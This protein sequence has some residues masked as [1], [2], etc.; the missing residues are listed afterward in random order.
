MKT[1]AILVSAQGEQN[2]GAD[3]VRVQKFL[4]ISLTMLA[5]SAI[6]A[7]W[8]FSCSPV[9]SPRIKVLRRWEAHRGPINDLVFSQDRQFLISAGWDGKIRLWKVK[10]G[11]LIKEFHQS[12]PVK[13]VSLSPNGKMLVTSGYD[14]T[15]KIWRFEDGI[16]LSLLKELKGHKDWVHDAVFSPDGQFLASGGKDAT[17]KI[18]I[19]SNG[20]LVRTLT[21]H[22]KAVTALAFSPDGKFLASGSEDSTVKIW[23]FPQGKL[24]K[25]LT[26]D[27]PGYAVNCIR[28]SPDGKLLAG[29]CVTIKVWKIPEWQLVKTLVGHKSGLSE[30]IFSPNSRYLI[31]GSSDGRLKVWELE[32]GEVIW[33]WKESKA[34]LGDL[35]VQL[36]HVLQLYRHGFSLNQL[37][38]CP[39]PTTAAFSPDGQTL[40]LGLTNGEILL[41]N[42]V[43]SL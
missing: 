6:L 22:S 11:K 16:L 18:W 25:T 36:D 33:E 38:A 3:K 17:I 30:V 12:K 40:A 23:Q 2:M 15:I 5:L 9:I 13:F 31:S 4:T 19:V 21:G 20:Q 24:L 42:W 14:K 37:I 8:Y 1:L 32:T 35:A 43:N 34:L 41:L 28:F 26:G 10:D 39:D 27:M 7:S 29:G